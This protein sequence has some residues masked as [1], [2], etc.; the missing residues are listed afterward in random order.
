MYREKIWRPYTESTAI[1]AEI[2]LAVS[3]CC[4]EET[5][6]AKGRIIAAQSSHRDDAKKDVAILICLSS[7]ENCQVMK[8]SVRFQ[9]SYWRKYFPKHFVQLLR[10]CG[11]V[12]SL[13]YMYLKVPGVS[14]KLDVSEGICG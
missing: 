7:D 12:I 10:R 3:P 9:S 5:V 4:H 2:A 1:W 11:H 13:P 14:A 6:P 8:R